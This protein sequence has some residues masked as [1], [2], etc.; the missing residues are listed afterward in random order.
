[1]SRASP[2]GHNVAYGFT[3]L[4]IIITAGN[5][6]NFMKKIQLKF[7]LR[8]GKRLTDPT[9]RH[10][11]QNWQV[12]EVVPS[13]SS[14]WLRIKGDFLARLAHVVVQKVIHDIVDGVAL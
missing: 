3:P 14:P 6:I 5:Q 10:F 9:M 2:H 7:L 12:R 13:Q 11:L 4:S 1:M 8:K